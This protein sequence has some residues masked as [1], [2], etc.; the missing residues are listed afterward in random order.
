MSVNRQEARGED[1]SQS[2]PSQ[3]SLG[4]LASTTQEDTFMLLFDQQV[5]HNPPHTNGDCTRAVVYTLAQKDLD[6]PHPINSKNPTQWNMRFFESLENKGFILDYFPNN[7]KDHWPRFVGRSGMSLRE[8]RH[9]VV[10]DRQT[11]KMIHDPNPKRDGLI[12]GTEDGWFILRP[13]NYR[14]EILKTQIA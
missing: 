10:W 5:L 3:P 14:T 12:S 13:V 6:L 9:L 7:E 1:R 2:R 4:T 8:V 11:N